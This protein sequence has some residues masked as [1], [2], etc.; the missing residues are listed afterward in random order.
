MFVPKELD[1]SIIVNY[2]DEDCVLK[3]VMLK[4]QPG[5]IIE[6]VPCECFNFLLYRLQELRGKEY[7]FSTDRRY[8]KWRFILFGERD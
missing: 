5:E 7:S 6:G 3:D 4:V 2:N 8:G 1:E